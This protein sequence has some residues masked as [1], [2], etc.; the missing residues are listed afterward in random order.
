MKV[1]IGKYVNWVGPYQISRLLKYVGAD[2]DL[3]DVVGDRLDKSWVKNACRFFYKYQTRKVK[4]K[5]HD[6]DTWGM[7]STLALI[8]LP[9]LKQLKET[10]HGTPIVMDAFNYSNPDH[11][12]GDQTVFDFYKNDDQSSEI[13]S[14]QWDEIMDKMI[15]AFEALQPDSNWEDQFWVEKPILDED[16]MSSPFGD[17]EVARE[18]KWKAKGKHDSVGYENY[19]NRIQ[20]GL[21]LFGTYFQNLW[22]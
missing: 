4:I 2:E 19:Q 3:C 8:I 6:Y 13:A 10:K 21:I 17:G 15:F 1:V 5:I 12:G 7:D 22:D 9:M 14:K 18:I 20:E 11:M 16:D